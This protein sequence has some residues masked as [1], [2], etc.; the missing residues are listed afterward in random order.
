MLRQGVDSARPGTIHLTNARIY[1][2]VAFLDLLGRSF[3]WWFNCA[4]QELLGIGARLG[5]LTIGPLGDNKL[6]HKQL[7]S[8]PKFCLPYASRRMTFF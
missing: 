1:E 4:D 8:L 3:R 2:I 5:R 6:P 7:D